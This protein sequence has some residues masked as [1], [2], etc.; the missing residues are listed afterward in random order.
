MQP[1]GCTST[2]TYDTRNTG[3]YSNRE[4]RQAHI[5]YTSMYTLG[6]QHDALAVNNMLTKCLRTPVS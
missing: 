6:H 4:L 2:A 5:Q 1:K 3:I